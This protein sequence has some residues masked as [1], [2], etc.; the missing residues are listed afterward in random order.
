[1]V[2]PYSHR[3][4]RVQWYSGYSLLFF[5]FAYETI[6]LCGGPSHALLLG[7][8]MHYAVQTPAIFLQPVWPLPRSLATTCGISVDFFSSPY[9]DV[10]VQAVPHAHLW[11]QCTLTELHSAGFPHSDTHGS[12]PAFGSPWL[13]AD[14][15]VLRRLLVPRHSPCALCSLTI[16]SRS[17][18]RLCVRITWFFGLFLDDN[19]CV[20]HVISHMVTLSLPFCLLY[21][22]SVFKVQFRALL[23]VTLCLAAYVFLAVSPRCFRSLVGSSGLEPPTSRLSGVRSNHLSYEPMFA[24]TFGRRPLSG[25]WWR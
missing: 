15:C 22:C 4:S 21:L 25:P 8:N 16:K 19:F 24:R 7:S 11:I 9:L 12:M 18:F 13:F 20:V 23:R 6:T 5:P 1:M 17:G 14:C 10:S 3:V 2:P